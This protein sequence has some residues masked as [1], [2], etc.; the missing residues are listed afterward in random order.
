MFGACF[1]EDF[2]YAKKSHIAKMGRAAVELFGQKLTPE[3]C[4]IKQYQD[5]LALSFIHDRIPPGSRV[6]EVGGGYSRVLKFLSR[7]YEC[8]NIDKLDGLG[9]GPTNVAK[10]KSLGCRLV[11][12]YMGD[13]TPELPN[14][15]FDF[16]FSISALEHTPGNQPET[17]DRIYRDIQRVAKNGTWSLH[18]FDFLVRESGFWMSDCMMAFF[19]LARPAYA[20]PD[21]R[22]ILSDP[23]IFVMSR[24][25]YESS[26]KQVIKKPYDEFGRPS[27]ITVLWQ[28]KK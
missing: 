1:P 15:Y 22:G 26:W 5:L 7:D 8:W 9:N 27:N 20:L 23:D 17:Y 2:I 4:Q 12:A 19:Q 18:L 3:T 25:E 13:F 6:L 14:D 24:E 11:C 21:Q 28:V 10:V 16:V